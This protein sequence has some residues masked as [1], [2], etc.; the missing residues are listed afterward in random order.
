MAFNPS[1]SQPVVIIDKM[2]LLA[3]PITLGKY[4]CRAYQMQE[5]YP[6]SD[7][8]EET[9]TRQTIDH[10]LEVNQVQFKRTTERLTKLE[11]Q[12]RTRAVGKLTELNEAK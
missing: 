9:E 1:Q 3:D 10:L 11:I 12:K 5:L 8:E 6:M 2:N 4:I 7:E